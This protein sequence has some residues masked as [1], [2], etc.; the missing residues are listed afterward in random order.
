MALSCALLSAAFAFGYGAKIY[1]GVRATGES[2]AGYYAGK[3]GGKAAG[4]VGGTLFGW[5]EMRNSLLDEAEAVG[6]GI[7]DVHFSR[8]P[9]L[10][11]RL[12]VNADAFGDEFLVK[13]VHGVHNE[14]GHA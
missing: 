2:S 4:G 6:V 8:A 1:G 10:V 9:G 7:L 14:V 13:S 12:D 11:D 3:R 5:A